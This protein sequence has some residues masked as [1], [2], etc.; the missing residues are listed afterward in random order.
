[1]IIL[2]LNHNFVEFVTGMPVKEFYFQIIVRIT[3]SFYL[4]SWI[5]APFYRELSEKLDDHLRHMS[6]QRI[7]KQ[8]STI[9]SIGRDLLDVPKSDGGKKI[10][11]LWDRNSPQGPILVWMM[12]IFFK[13]KRWILYQTITDW[14]PKESR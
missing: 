10:L 8:C 11:P 12:V 3:Y 13:F 9:N 7:P 1:M 5:S 14:N 2:I 4:E 6:S